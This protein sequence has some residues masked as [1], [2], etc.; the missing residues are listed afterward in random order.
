M[1]RILAIFLLLLVV[2]SASLMQFSTAAISIRQGNRDAL[3]LA[4]A[5]TSF[6]A[7]AIT[8]ALLSRILVAVSA[9]PAPGSQDMKES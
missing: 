7:F 3:Q 1:N 5:A 8:F 2:A 4:L 9:R 6:V